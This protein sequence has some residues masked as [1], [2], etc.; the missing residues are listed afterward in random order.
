MAW[1]QLPLPSLLQPVHHRSH[2]EIWS[3]AGNHQRG[4]PHPPVQ[5]M[6]PRRRRPALRNIAS[7]ATRD[8]RSHFAVTFR[9]HISRSHFAV[10]FRGQDENVTVTL[11][12][13]DP[14][15]ETILRR[16]LLRISS[17][18]RCVARIIAGVMARSCRGLIGPSMR[19]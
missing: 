4:L 15:A 19:A 3:V 18:F 16:P 17:G 11:F 2:R 8:G 12:V 5:P 10:T 14:S 13:Q 6:E 7:K 9:G 1:R